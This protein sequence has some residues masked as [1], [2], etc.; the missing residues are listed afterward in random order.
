MI[1]KKGED[2][3]NLRN[4]KLIIGILSVFLLV[5]LIVIFSLFNHSSPNTNSS[6]ETT[7]SSS[8][9]QTI[10]P[11]TDVI[12]GDV[13]EEELLKKEQTIDQSKGE[14]EHTHYHTQTIFDTT[15]DTSSLNTY[16]ISKPITLENSKVPGMSREI[17]ASY[18]GFIFTYASG[19]EIFYYDPVK[20]ETRSLTKDVTKVFPSFN[21]P[22]IL[23]EKK[24][25]KGYTL[26]RY[27]FV[28]NVNGFEDIVVLNNSAIDFGQHNEF[29]YFSIAEQP[30]TYFYQSIRGSSYEAEEIGF[31]SVASKKIEPYK[32]YL[33]SYSKADNA[34]N[35]IVYGKEPE[36]LLELPKHDDLKYL[37]DLK[38]NP[39]R[40]DKLVYL[41]SYS[42][43]EDDLL[44]QK[45]ILNGTTV[46]EL[47]NVIDMQWIDKESIL[48]TADTDS[49]EL[50][51]FNLRTKEKIVL[52]INVATF[53]YNEDLKTI[54]YIEVGDDSLKQISINSKN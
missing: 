10:N 50:Y 42:S 44:G 17:F 1:K 26:Y 29:N 24:T 20:R 48:Y 4:R 49:G 28:K 14:E 30:N 25:D 40:T 38:V 35:K 5:A 45:V 8:S 46:P 7:T 34:L 41:A 52:A 16:S 37:I 39:F 33:V 11:E 36:K 13:T 54:N 19:N 6:N 32:D 31:R 23:F 18:K 3:L 9:N 2:N 15:K 12:Y 43:I 53:K 51:L 22:Y 21:K 47:I 27:N